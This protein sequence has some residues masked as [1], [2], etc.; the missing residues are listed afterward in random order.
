MVWLP[1]DEKV[2]RHITIVHVQVF[3]GES[4][5]GMAT[6]LNLLVFLFLEKQLNTGV[7]QEGS[8]NVNDPIE[9]F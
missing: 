7:D 3:T 8:E 9:S 6:R 2:I 4:H 1:A 5:N